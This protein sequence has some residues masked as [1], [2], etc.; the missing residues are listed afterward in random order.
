LIKPAPDN[1]PRAIHE[2][3]WSAI[4]AGGINLVASLAMMVL[5]ATGLL[6]WSRRKARRRANRARGRVDTHRLAQTP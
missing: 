5:L 1:W 4:L 3:T 2:G 6:I